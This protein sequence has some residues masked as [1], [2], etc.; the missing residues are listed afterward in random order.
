MKLAKNNKA[1]IIFILFFIFIVVAVLI[2][3]F[4]KPKHK[5]QSNDSAQNTMSS[6]NSNDESKPQDNMDID[7]PDSQFIV[8]N[9]NR[10]I[11][12]SYE[13]GD[14]VLPNVALN[15]QKSNSEN[16]IRYIMSP[17]LESLFSDAKDNNLELMLAS[18]YRSAELQGFYYNSLV[19]SMGQTEADKVSAKPGTSE[20]QTGLAVDLAPA[21]RQCYLETCFSQLPEGVWLKDNAYKYGFIL[22]YPQGKAEITGYQF[23]PW[24]FR[25]VGKEL[26]QKIYS[27]NTTLE[28]YF[29]L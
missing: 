9:K 10:P 25:Y 20:H 4:A 1:K 23:E 14:L 27:Q 3:V 13:P 21:N 16:S 7:N 22:R 8:V 2:F 17:H 26:A 29:N 11:L 19:Q 24:H 15:S 28:E 18:G 5:I 6:I 12:L